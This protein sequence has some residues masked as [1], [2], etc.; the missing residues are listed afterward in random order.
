V[1]LAA[2]LGDQATIITW[3]GGILIR[4]GTEPQ[5]GDRNMGQW[6]EANVAVNRALRPIRFEEY[7]D[8]KFALIDVPP[9][10]D[11]L[12]ETL[13]WVRRFDRPGDGD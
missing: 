12:D 3:D 10:F 11:A 8:K 7:P 2:S 1:A 6:P 4:A 9:P 5:I 13:K